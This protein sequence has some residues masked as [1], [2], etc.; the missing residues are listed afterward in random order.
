[1]ALAKFTRRLFV[2]GGLATCALIPVLYHNVSCDNKKGI[3]FFGIKI[4]DDGIKMPGLTINDQGIE[5]SGIKINENGINVKGMKLGVDGVEEEGIDYSNSST[6][7]FGSFFGIPL[8]VTGKYTVTRDDKKYEF[9][10][11]RDILHINDKS[12][13]IKMNGNMNVSIK[14][15][16]VIINDNYIDLNDY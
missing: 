12:T 15:K 16:E 8:F 9:T 2:G 13:N 14:N 11:I 1:M 3:N 10:V 5:G 4:N 7:S 6:F